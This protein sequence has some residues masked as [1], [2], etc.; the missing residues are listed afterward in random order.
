M[1][2]LLVA[3]ISAPKA[4]ALSARTGLANHSKTHSTRYAQSAASFMAAECAFCESLATGDRG[5]P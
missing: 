1:S 5:V 4:Y 2:Q 3:K